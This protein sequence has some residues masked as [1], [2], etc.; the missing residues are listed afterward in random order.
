MASD[1][2]VTQAIHS[3]MEI[4]DVTTSKYEWNVTVSPYSKMLKNFESTGTYISLKNIQINKG[5]L[6][7]LNHSL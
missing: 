7:S 2:I 3:V 1:I 4:A 6:A 5:D